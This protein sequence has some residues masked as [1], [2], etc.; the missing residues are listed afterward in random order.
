[1]SSFLC[2]ADT[3]AE[4]CGVTRRRLEQLIQQGHLPTE[5]RP[6]RGTYALDLTCRYYIE[7]L[8][9]EGALSKKV[10]DESTIDP[11]EERALLHREQRLKLEIQNAQ[12]MR[13]VLL[14]TEVLVALEKL[15]IVYNNQIDAIEG[16]IAAKLI[17]ATQADADT[18][19]SVLRPELVAIR[20]E[21]AHAI[22]TLAH[23]FASGSD[24]HAPA[25]DSTVAM[26][27]NSPNFTT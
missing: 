24:S 21:I 9:Q 5:C 15:Q 19:L 1:M 27:G 25:A 8:K 26:G 23:S 10:T 17:A 13:T 14:A 12:Y 6:K 2:S 7:F 16:R 3:A 20:T 22:S 4:V 11:R 18:I